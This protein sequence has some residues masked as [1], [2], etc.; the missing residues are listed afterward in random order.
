[1]ECKNLRPNNPLLLSAV[2]RT[3]D[4]AFHYLLVW[5]PRP[6]YSNYLTERVIGNASAY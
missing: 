6:I 1:V 2:P 3:S 4:E 5:R